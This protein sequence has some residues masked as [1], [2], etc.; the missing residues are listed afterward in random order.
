VVVEKVVEEVMEGTAE[1]EEALQ[2]HL[3]QLVKHKHKLLFQWQQMSNQLVNYHRYL[4]ECSIKQM[5]S[6]KKSKPT[7]ESTKMSPD[8]TSP[9]EKLQS[10][11]PLS[12]DLMLKDGYVTWESGS[13]GSTPSPITSQMYGTN[14][15]MNLEVNS[16]IP[17][18]NN[19]PKWNSKSLGCNFCTLKSI[20]QN[21]R[22]SADK[23]DIPKAAK[24]PSTSSL[25]DSLEKFWL[26]SSNHP[27]SIIM[28]TSK[29]KLSNLLNLTSFL[30]QSLGASKIQVLL[31]ILECKAINTI[32]SGH[33]LI[34]TY[35]NNP[36]TQEETRISNKETKEDKTEDT[37]HPMPPDQ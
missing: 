28:T 6:S 13:M 37:R 31:A 14:S 32:A 16:K 17:T 23:Q 10:P 9:F 8:L 3:N 33:L 11:S 12:K 18:S 36:S 29:P 7:S 1:E 22:T 4:M 34:E 30:M 2:E 24:K 26:M 5:L 19:D 35:H 15:Y 21:L 20:S 27:L 25:E